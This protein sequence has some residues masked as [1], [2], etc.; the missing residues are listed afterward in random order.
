MDRVLKQVCAQ[1]G[2]TLKGWE[3]RGVRE[4]ERPVGF[5]CTSK[6]TQLELLLSLAW[7]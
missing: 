1:R 2:I 6:S 4:A 5:A 3:F 7:H